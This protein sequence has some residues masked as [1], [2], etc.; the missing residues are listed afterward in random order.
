MGRSRAVD[1]GM[2]FQTAAVRIHR[3][4]FS[5]PE[6]SADALL[7]NLSSWGQLLYD[8]IVER[9]SL[10]VPQRTPALSM[11]SE[12]VLSLERHHSAQLPSSWGQLLY[13]LVNSQTRF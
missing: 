11:A 7:Q 5:R 9:L 1:L 4:N 12:P 10:I 3:W 8:R 6:T 2:K 13:D